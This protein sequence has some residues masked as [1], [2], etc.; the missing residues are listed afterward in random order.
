MYQ[1]LVDGH[2]RFYAAGPD[3]ELE[4]VPDA[5]GAITSLVLHQNGDHSAKKR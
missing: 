3:A 1:G 2:P 5:S 4:F